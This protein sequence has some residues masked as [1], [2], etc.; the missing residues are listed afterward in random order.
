MKICIDARMIT[1]RLHGI[2]RYALNLIKELKAI[3]KENPYLL[4]VNDDYL[5]NF[6]SD[7]ENFRLKIVSAKLYT[8]LEQMVIP[9]ILKRERIDLF[10]SLSY[11]APIFQPC[12]TV[13]TIHD[14]IPW[15]FHE[16][17][18]FIHKLYYRLIVKG[19]AIKAAKIITVSNSSKEDLVKY[20]DI[21]ENKIVVIYNGVDEIYGPQ[22]DLSVRKKVKRQFC[23]ERDFILYLG[24][25]K[26]HKNAERAIKSFLRL[27]Q[28]KNP[29]VQLV[30]VGLG[31]QFIS[32]LGVCKN[33]SKNIL[34]FEGVSDEE[35]VLLYN[36]ANL[37]VFPS[38]Y[39]GFGFPPLEAMACGTPVITSNTSS[40][41]ELVGDAAIK[42]N[43][44]SVEGLYTAMYNM[45]TDKK[46]QSELIKKGLEQ[47]KQFS[48]EE[49]AR[50]TMNTYEGIWVSGEEM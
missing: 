4:L 11:S 48:W 49:T 14:L 40:I 28:E 3:D 6:I 50:H 47:V 33:L 36:A 19:A 31:K 25:P 13:M 8:V 35:L 44:Y 1:S 12:P 30:M 38:L 5:R 29:P 27:K 45:L 22:K 42:V 21:P 46:M 41:P 17:Y 24:N 16:D 7:A 26:P 18:P 32:S 2:S 10:H 39:E 43:P 9:V 37:L 23:I 20:F 34:F 15:I